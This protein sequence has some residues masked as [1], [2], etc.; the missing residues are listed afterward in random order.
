[1]KAYIIGSSDVK[2]EIS[3]AM[4]ETPSRSSS[5]LSTRTPTTPSMS[6]RTRKPESSSC[7]MVSWMRLFLSSI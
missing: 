2:F 4:E 7:G 1:M 6:A 3:I 5:V